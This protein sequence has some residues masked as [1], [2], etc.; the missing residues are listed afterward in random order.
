MEIFSSSSYPCIQLIKMELP[1]VLQ[2]SPFKQLP[3]DP[4]TTVHELINFVAPLQQQEEEEDNLLIPSAAANEFT[5]PFAL[6]NNESFPP[7]NEPDCFTRLLPD[8]G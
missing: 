7:I 3:T 1:E 8:G 6:I 5:C 2:Y 4:C